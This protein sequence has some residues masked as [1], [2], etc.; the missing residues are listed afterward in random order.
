M[1]LAV[2]NADHVRK[3]H[4]PYK[5]LFPSYSWLF[6]LAKLNIPH[7]SCATKINPVVQTGG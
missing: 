4:S 1:F 5:L 2:L 7:L 3:F 6:V